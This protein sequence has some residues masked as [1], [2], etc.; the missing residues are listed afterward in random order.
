LPYSEVAHCVA[1]VTASGAWAATKLALEFIV[2]TACRSGEAR[3]ALWKEMDFDPNDKSRPATWTIP[4]ER[5][6]QGRS[7]RVPLSSRAV[8][9]LAE[10]RKLDDGSGLVFPSIRGKALSDMTLSKL[11]KELGFGVDVHGFRTSFRTWAQEQTDYPREVQEAALGHK[12]GDAAEQAYARSD[13]FAKRREMMEDWA[14]F[15]SCAQEDE[16]WGGGRD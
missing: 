10:A 13:Y 9:I 5:A 11:V 4:G 1:T 6:K 16:V 8:E 12:V 14:Q 15:L 7:H 2:L 3:L